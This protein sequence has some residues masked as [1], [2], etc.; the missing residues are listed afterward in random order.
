MRRFYRLDVQP[1]LF[2]EWLLIREWG[3][4]GRAGQERM[5]PFATAEEAQEALAR[6]QRRQRAGPKR[7]DALVE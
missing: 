4:I 3:R 2:G 1:D 7:R 5:V 6:K